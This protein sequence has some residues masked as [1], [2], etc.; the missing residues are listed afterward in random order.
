MQ[1]QILQLD[2]QSDAR[3]WL[4]KVIMRGQL[5]AGGEFGEIYVVSARPGQVRGSHYHA[6]TTEWFCLLEGCAILRL[7]ELDSGAQCT[8]K[9][10][11]AA[12]VVV[13]VAPRTAHAIE[14]TGTV[15]A[16]L[17][18]YADRP[19]TAAAPDTYPCKM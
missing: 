3:G 5:G 4:L 11:G 17:L 15:P 13:A 19:Y 8:I 2:R 10:D 18:A 14:A 7:A 16:V 12:P 9:L 1:P 6:G